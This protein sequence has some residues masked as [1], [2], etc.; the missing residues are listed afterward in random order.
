M[1]DHEPGTGS[2]PTIRA[3]GGVVWRPSSQ[4][5]AGLEVLVVHRDRYDDWSFPKGKLDPGESWE[6]AAVREVFEE[7]GVVG[8]L[9]EELATTDYV[10]HRGRTKRA[11]YWSMQVAADVGFTADDEISRRRWLPVGEVA[12]TLTYPRDAPVLESFVEQRARADEN[13]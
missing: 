4:D 13:A 9:G 7:T 8:V 3:A 6:Q 5:D 11:R 12:E 2:K 1:T 10:D